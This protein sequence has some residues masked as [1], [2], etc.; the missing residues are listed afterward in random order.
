VALVVGIGIGYWGATNGT[1]SN[2]VQSVMGGP[3]PNGVNPPLPNGVNPPKRDQ[4]TTP[5]Q[6]DQAVTPSK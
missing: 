5:I 3:S 4:G 6:P 1:V 2:M